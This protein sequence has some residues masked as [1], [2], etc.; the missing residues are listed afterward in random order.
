[1]KT[2]HDQK[3]KKSQTVYNIKI[4]KDIQISTE[5]WSDQFAVEENIS[6]L[7]SLQPPRNTKGLQNVQRVL[8]HE[9]RG[10]ESG[11]AGR[12]I[13][14][15]AVVSREHYFTPC[16]P[17]SRATPVVLIPSMQAVEKGEAVTLCAYFSPLFSLQARARPQATTQACM[18]KRIGWAQTQIQANLT[19][20]RKVQVT[21]LLVNK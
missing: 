6:S 5:V 14:V 13:C 4:T 2:C 16:S 17:A 21:P 11:M 12:G 7:R 3:I 10:E 15:Q 20:D 19:V 8:L 9:L 18:R 1:M